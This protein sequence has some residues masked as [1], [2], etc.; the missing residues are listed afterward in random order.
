MPTLVQS[1]SGG[2]SSAASLTVTLTSPT[3]AGNCLVV[4]VATS[5]SSSGPTVSGITLG[6]AAGNFAR[7]VQSSS[8]VIVH[9]EIW[10]D[11]NC[12]GGQTSVVITLTGGAGSFP[13]VVA[14]VEE[15]S[16]V[17]TSLAVDKT[18]S[19][20]GNSAA[21]SS[22]ATGTTTQ[23]SEVI[24]GCGAAQQTP[25]GPSSPWTNLAVVSNT[26]VTTLSM[27]AGWQVA[28]ATGT[29]TY[30]GTNASANWAAC[31]VTLLAATGPATP[32][33]FTPPVAG[34]RGRAAVRRGR[35]A[36]SRGAPVIAP[37]APKRLLISLASAAGTDDSGT[38]YPQGITAFEQISGTTYTLQ[39]GQQTFGSTTAPA[40]FVSNQGSAPFLPPCYTAAQV[41]LSGCGAEIVS[42][43]A[44]AGTQ[45][46]A[47]VVLDSALSGVPGGLI[48]LIAGQTLINTSASSATPVPHGSIT[49]LAQLVSLLQQAGILQ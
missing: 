22:G 44:T 1:K 25:T 3:T 13:N 2:A 38:A 15:W 49:T 43:Q 6:G 35:S 17:A 23:A 7:A 27:V 10:T 29:F 37:P 31:V 47:I 21:F 39:L 46:A 4:K 18:S 19:N 36:S 33:P 16:G 20:N 42:G 9:S 8:A 5:E 34:P 48:E 11:Q 32:S 24:V 28:S 40:F 26:N 45:L 30:S 14:W 12:A 41:S